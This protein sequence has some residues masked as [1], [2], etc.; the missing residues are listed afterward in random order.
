MSLVRQAR[1]TALA[2]LLG[3][4]LGSWTSAGT[5]DVRPN[6]RAEEPGRDAAQL[7]GLHNDVGIF[8]LD[9]TYTVL[10]DGSVT[11]LR[12]RDLGPLRT[13]NG[14]FDA[15]RRTIQLFGAQNQE[16]AVQLVVPVQGRRF[17]ARAE[18]P[19]GVPADRVTFSAIAWSRV[20]A[21]APAQPE[22]FSQT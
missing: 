5:P 3:I 10:P 17:S 16:V 19:D 6:A 15:D 7:P 22:T 4:L 9:P 8:A 18:G 2:G 13:R 20:G 14:Y 11:E 12:N 1:L 21:A